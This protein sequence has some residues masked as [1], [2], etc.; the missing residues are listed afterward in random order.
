M[1]RYIL[2]FHID[3]DLTTPLTLVYLCPFFAACRR[4]FYSYSFSQPHPPPPPHQE[5]VCDENFEKKCQ[6]TFRQQAINETV[7]KCYK[8]TEKVRYMSKL[9]QKVN[10][11]LICK[12]VILVKKQI[13]PAIPV[14]FQTEYRSFFRQASAILLLF[15][16]FSV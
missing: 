4:V 12:K 7:R 1:C 15:L 6:I 8:P 13:W 5:E 11:R 3:P 16:F 10:K 14:K 2:Y 9:K